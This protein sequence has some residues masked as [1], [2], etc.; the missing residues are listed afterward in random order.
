MDLSI[1]NNIFIARVAHYCEC[2]RVEFTEDDLLF[3]EQCREVGDT[4]EE[5]GFSVLMYKNRHRITEDVE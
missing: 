3:I 1:E 2:K 5:A 4:P